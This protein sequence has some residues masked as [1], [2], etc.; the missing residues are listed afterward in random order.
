MQHRTRA[1][2]VRQTQTRLERAGRWRAVRATQ[3]T[4]D[5]MGKPVQL[6]SQASTRRLPG[7]PFVQTV[8][9]AS[10]LPHQQPLLRQRVMLPVPQVS[11]LCQEHLSV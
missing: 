1:H 9:Q 5:W 8:Q 4:L 11:I 7:A 6:V 10:I 3:A 2:H